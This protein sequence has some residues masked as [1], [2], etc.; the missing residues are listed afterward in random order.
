MVNWEVYILFSEKPEA[1]TQTEVYFNLVSQRENTALRRRKPQ[2]PDKVFRVHATGQYLLLFVCLC[3]AIIPCVEYKD[4]N[5]Y[6][7]FHF[8]DYFRYEVY[9]ILQII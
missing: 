1:C 6:S 2:K 8:P 5:I 9:L 3:C 7:K 4:A